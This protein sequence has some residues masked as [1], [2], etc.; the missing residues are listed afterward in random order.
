[1]HVTEIA[2][3]IVKSQQPNRPE[4]AV[5]PRPK[6]PE[7]G[8]S[9]LIAE[10]A[11]VDALHEETEMAPG[12][13]VQIKRGYR[14]CYRAQGSPMVG[15]VQDLSPTGSVARIRCDD[16]SDSYILVSHLEPADADVLLEPGMLS[17]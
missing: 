13:V 7:L 15:V 4:V 17:G 8:I 3:L 12:T 9:L 11:A 1:M 5:A 14:H 6:H 16:L 10:F 2:R